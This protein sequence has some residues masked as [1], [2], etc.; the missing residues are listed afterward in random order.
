MLLDLDNQDQMIDDD[1]STPGYSAWDSSDENEDKTEDAEDTLLTPTQLLSMAIKK[2][3]VLFSNKE[4][5]YRCEL[6]HTALI[7]SLCKHLGESRASRRHQRKRRRGRRSRSPRQAK[8][9]KFAIAFNCR[10][11]FAHGARQGRRHPR[12]S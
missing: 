3:R 12:T 4:R 2:R 8:Y 6:L 10:R 9:A 7:Q 11:A 1:S 5:D